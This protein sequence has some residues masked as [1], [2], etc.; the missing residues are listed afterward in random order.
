MGV[1]RVDSSRVPK[2]VLGDLQSLL[3]SS[4]EEYIV[5]GKN[6]YSIGPLPAIQLMDILGRF[7]TMLDGVRRQKI[8]ES[9]SYL[10]G[11]ELQNFDPSSIIVSVQDLLTDPEATSFIKDLLK[12]IL[13][14]TEENDFEEM[15]VGQMT[16][17]IDKIIKVNMETLPQSFVNNFE[18]NA[19]QQGL[20]TNLEGVEQENSSKNP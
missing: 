16:N 8:E 5:V 6:F 14:G 15:S 18:K 1:K 20:S 11:E 3:S 17:T 19:E 13:D 9:K 10:S 12:E 4:K 2:E 7:L